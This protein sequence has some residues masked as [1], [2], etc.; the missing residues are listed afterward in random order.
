MG[1]I[2]RDDELT[3]IE[4]E[5]VR[6]EEAPVSEQSP[7]LPSTPVVPDRDRVPA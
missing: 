5:P 7:A 6:P 1:D 4:F 3:E 2:G